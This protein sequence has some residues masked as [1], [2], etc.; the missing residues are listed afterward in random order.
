MDRGP[1]SLRDVFEQ[2]TI[3]ALADRTLPRAVANRTQ[4][5]DAWQPH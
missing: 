1:G 2:V 4:S 3:R 5:E